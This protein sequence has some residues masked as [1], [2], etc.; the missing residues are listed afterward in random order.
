MRLSR[1]LDMVMRQV[2]DREVI[3]YGPNGIR[4]FFTYRG[5][6]R[7]GSGGFRNPPWKFSALS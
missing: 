5:V 2:T 3:P 4:L 7:G 6:G 1:W